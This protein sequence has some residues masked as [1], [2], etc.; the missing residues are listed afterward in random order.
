[1]EF[2]SINGPQLPVDGCARWGEYVGQRK[3]PEAV[4][5]ALDHALAE[6]LQN[7]VHYSQAK[8]VVVG[9]DVT[10]DVARITVTDDGIP[11]DPTQFAAVNTSA[12]IRERPVGGLGI[13]M[14]R[15]LTD[16]MTYRR[17]EGRNCLELL[18]RFP[19]A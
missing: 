16:G 14:M 8:R 9:F 15:K 3:L 13:H 5:F 1:M 10:A 11:F 6:H 18:K 19:A 7:I 17:A 2:V 12:P 4:G